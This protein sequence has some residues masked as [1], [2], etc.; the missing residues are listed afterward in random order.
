MK[1]E[2]FFPLGFSHQHDLSSYGVLSNFT[3]FGGILLLWV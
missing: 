1:I 2:V 3:V